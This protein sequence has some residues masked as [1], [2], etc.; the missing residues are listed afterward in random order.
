MFIYRDADTT[1]SIVTY[2]INIEGQSVQNDTDLV[3]SIIL[4]GARGATQE[5]V[6]DNVGEGYSPSRQ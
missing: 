1:G 3:A 5:F 2:T 6:L 4:Y